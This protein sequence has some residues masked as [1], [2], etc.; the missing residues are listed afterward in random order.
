MALSTSLFSK[1][2][3]RLAVWMLGVAFVTWLAGAVYTVYLS[4]D[5]RFFTGA[6][7]IKQAW[8]ASMNAEHGPKYVLYGGSSCAFSLDAERLLQRHQLAAVNMGS[9]AAMGASVLSQAALEETRAGDVLVVA[10][11]PILL[12]DSLEPPSFGVQMAFALGRRG[13]VLHPQVGTNST[14]WSSALLALRPGGTRTLTLLSKLLRPGE[15]FRYHLT[16]VRPSGF[17][18]TSARPPFTG[19]S[20]PGGRLTDDGRILLGAL[21]D[22]GKRNQVRVV[23]SL[24]WSYTAPDKAAWFRRQN[25]QFLLDVAEVV[26]VLYDPR[27]GALSN[28]ELFADTP[29]H[30]SEKGAALRTDELADQLKRWRLWTVEELRERVQARLDQE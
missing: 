15:L 16:D 28:K 10:L 26:P 19:P 29:L 2:V 13:W 20:V 3:P 23:Y 9:A 22:W 18:Q 24:R 17:M 30:L 8:S 4:P 11:E 6:A 5:I 25:A 1:Q 27:L 12:T 21:R 7:R 14:P